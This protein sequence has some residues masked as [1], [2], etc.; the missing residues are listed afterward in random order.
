M[1]QESMHPSAT[2]VGASSGRCVALLYELP[3]FR[4]VL[5]RVRRMCAGVVRRR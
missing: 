1:W 3:A 5:L 2:V 4:G